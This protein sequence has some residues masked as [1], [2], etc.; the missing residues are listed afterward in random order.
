MHPD[1]IYPLPDKTTTEGSYNDGSVEEEDLPEREEYIWERNGV[2][3]IP[4]SIGLSAVEA[5]L[6]LEMGTEKMLSSIL[7]PLR[8][9]YWSLSAAFFIS[10]YS[11]PC[12]YS[13]PHSSIDLMIGRM[14]SPS[15]D[16]A[17][18]TRGGTSGKT[19]RVIIPS[20]SIERRLSVRTFWLMPSRFF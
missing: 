18:S 7:E 3:F 19:V 8:G 12:L 14:D 1:E 6:S 15:S 4:V 20:A 16:K 11:S 2:D 5:K 17:Y 13:S 10:C 9:D